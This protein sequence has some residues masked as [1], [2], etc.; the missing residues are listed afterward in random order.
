LHFFLTDTSNYSDG[1]GRVNIV[2]AGN[3]NAGEGFS[4]WNFDST[5]SSFQ[6]KQLFVAGK[7]GIQ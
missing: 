3:A 2:S 7:D 6:Y 1:G 5:L 4:Y